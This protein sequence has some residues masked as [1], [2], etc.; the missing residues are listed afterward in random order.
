MGLVLNH[1]LTRGISLE[2][3]ADHGYSEAIYLSDPEGN[4]IEIYHDKPVEQWDIRDNGQII[5]V[6]EQWMLKVC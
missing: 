1:F 4:G 3:A 2:G 6:T 5:G